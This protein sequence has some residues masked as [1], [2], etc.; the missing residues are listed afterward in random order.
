M[1]LVQCTWYFDCQSVEILFS[2]FQLTW[3]L[4]LPQPI[5]LFRG[6]ESDVGSQSGGARFCYGGNGGFDRLNHLLSLSKVAEL[7]EA[8]PRPRWPKRSKPGATK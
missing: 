6:Q 7:V 2:T 4:P 5:N 1:Y 8:K 3:S